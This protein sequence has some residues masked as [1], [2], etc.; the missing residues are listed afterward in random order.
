MPLNRLKIDR[1]FI[2]SCS[3][4]DPALLAETVISLAQKLNLKTI[5]EGVEREEQAEY[6]ESLGCDEVQ[7]FLYAKPLRFNELSNTL[8]TQQNNDSPDNKLSS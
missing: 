7:G 8:Q 4:A 3:H 1:S 2:K 5:A 6:L